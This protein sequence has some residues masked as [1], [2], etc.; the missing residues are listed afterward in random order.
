MNLVNELQISAE[1]DDV[2]TVLRKARRL[3]SKLGATEILDWLDSEQSGYTTKTSLP[4]YRK[5]KGK[6]VYRTNGY[7][8][9]GYGMIMNGIADVGSGTF[10][11]DWYVPDS[12]SQVLVMIDAVTT[13]NH[14]LY[15]P[16]PNDERTEG[17]RS[18]F[19]SFVADQI[20]F[21]IELNRSHVVVIPEAVKDKVMDWALALERS[22]VSGEGLTF[23]DK[24]KTEAH[25]ITF[26]INNSKIE[27]LNNMGDNRKG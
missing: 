13:K 19:D 21:M 9:A 1:R 14:G 6:L 7:V 17:L 24:E 3:A 16:L 5:V 15:F 4:N 20:S 11:I 18:N 2:L 8:P 25:A 10:T 23:S 12:I 22:G 27:Q 26:N